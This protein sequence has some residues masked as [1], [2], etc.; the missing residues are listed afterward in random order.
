MPDPDHCSH[1]STRKTKLGIACGA[2]HT[3]C[4]SRPP[5]IAIA[6][7]MP[8]GKTDAKAM[9]AEAFRVAL[10]HHNVGSAAPSEANASAVADL[11]E[12]SDYEEE[13]DAKS[14]A[15][16]SKEN[17]KRKVSQLAKEKAALNKKVTR[18]F[19]SVSVTASPFKKA[20]AEADIA[21]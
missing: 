20:K 10:L 8:C 4:N 11:D 14:T 16:A 15:S 18:T 5:Q 2:N 19:R 17:P 3:D 7:T 21:K 1:T 9:L 13:E 6:T 12:F